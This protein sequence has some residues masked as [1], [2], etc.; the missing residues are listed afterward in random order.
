MPPSAPVYVTPAQAGY[1]QTQQAQ[2]PIG[3]SIASLILGICGFLF[4]FAGGFGVLPAIAGIITGH[5][6]YAKQ[7]RGR[8]LAIGGLITGYFGLVVSLVVLAFVIFAIVLAT[9]EGFSSSDYGE[10]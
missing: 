1:Y 4:S 3:L 6:A 9:N 5:I 7:P 10:Y 8:G 2:G